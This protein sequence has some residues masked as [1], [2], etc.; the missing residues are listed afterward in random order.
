VRRL[1]EEQRTR[2]GLKYLL[3]EREAEFNHYGHGQGAR[4]ARDSRAQRAARN[5][6]HQD[7]LRRDSRNAARI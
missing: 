5:A 6:A 2:T 1:L 7:Q 3:S 4:R